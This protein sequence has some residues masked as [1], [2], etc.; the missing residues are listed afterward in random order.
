MGVVTYFSCYEHDNCTSILM[1]NRLAKQHSEH[2]CATL[3][4]A[5]ERGVLKQ[6]DCGSNVGRT[7]LLIFSHNV[8]ACFKR[9]STFLLLYPMC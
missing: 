9:L 1:C 8:D 3:Y 5:A 7:S 6:N 2:E 4:S